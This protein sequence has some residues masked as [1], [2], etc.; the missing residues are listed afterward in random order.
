MR[1]PPTRV[2]FVLGLVSLITFS[3]F[4]QKETE[5]PRLAANLAA[6][7]LGQTLFHALR[8]CGQGPV[9]PPVC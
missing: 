6:A 3:H 7:S 5:P 1:L 4:W 8:G 9:P 2:V